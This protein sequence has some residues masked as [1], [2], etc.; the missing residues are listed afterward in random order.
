MTMLRP[1]DVKNMGFDQLNQ[2]D[3]AFG[4][5]VNGFKLM[6]FDTQTF[7]FD[8]ST[9]DFGFGMDLGIAGVHQMLD[10]AESFTEAATYQSAS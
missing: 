6:P 9:L 10:Q 1:I 5:D 8:T 7:P 4:E 3:S 2:L